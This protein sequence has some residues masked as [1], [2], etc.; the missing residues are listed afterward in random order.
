MDR[1]PV[2][3]P[4]RV[5]LARRWT[6]EIINTS[7]VPFARQEVQGFLAVHVDELLA[8][9]T[10]ADEPGP[11]A[12][13]VGSGLV[14]VHFTHTDALARTLRL[15]AAELPR[16]LPGAAPARIAAV[17]GALAAGFAGKL[18]C[19]TLEQQ[20]VIKQAVL[21]ARDA[22]EEA[23][24]ASEARSRAVFVSSAL[25]IA[26]ATL[27][28]TIEEVN[29]SMERI[30][31]CT[32]RRLVGDSM[33][34][35]A[36]Q[37]WIDD[38]RAAD[39]DL[40]VGRSE[41]FQRD[42]RFSGPDGAHI[43]TRLS[44][45]LVRDAHGEPD[46][47]V[48][49]YEDITERHM[50]QEQF[51]RQATHDPLTGLANRI[52]LKTTMDAALEPTHPGRRV[53][54]CYFDLDGFKAV[55]DSL[56]HP[57]GDDLLRAVAQRMQALTTGESMLTARMGGDEFVVL[58]ADSQGTARQLELVERIL[59]EITR[60]VRIGGHEL[61]A[62]ASVG[63]V[64]CEVAT[65]SPDELLRDADI[66]LY[67]AKADGRAQWMLFDPHRNADA[68][69]RFR[70]SA[71]MPAALEQNDMFVEYEPVVWLET[72][73]L[74]AA[75][76][77]LRWDHPELGEL[78]EEHF[79]ELA[80]ETGMITRLG[81]WLLE[82]V[83]EQAL[84]WARRF[85]RSAPI[86]RVNL[87]ARHFRDPELVGDLQRILRETGLPPGRLALGMPE[88]ALFD[89]SGDPLD[90]LDI[91][92]EMG[93][94]PTLFDFGRDLALIPRLRPL[95]LTAVQ[96]RGDYLDSFTEPAGPDPLDEHLVSSLAESARLLRVPVVAHGVRTDEQA[97]R[98]R[99]L[100]VRAVQGPY[101]GGR[102]SAGEI[103][104]ML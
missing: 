19:R 95:P 34:D 83:C 31:R 79:I 13:G 3:G 46:Y 8:A 44:A 61:T 65:T 92:A 69:R 9:M 64:E 74:V 52:L 50:L 39:G 23:L 18:R 91:I 51:R 35:L 80:E 30:F 88:S 29:P 36:D 26:I 37:D 86:A 54:L 98:L 67:R 82:R 42:L 48:L 97:K 10:A 6:Q 4:D 45:S 72:G 89:A 53:G 78:G 7:Y 75:D 93:V 22:A 96:I 70:L 103:E 63:V 32:G 2:S 14:E 17:L 68:R 59:A 41:R 100:G 66:T 99:Q 60:P 104:V 24:R 56:G 62:S 90:V 71:A 21:R 33:F 5:E 43:W 76:A 87:S 28:G 1:T 58:T 38:L 49:L 15:L 102:A 81:S 101:T 11:P 85:G 55:N 40:V 57:A 20:E 84:V 47:Q 77:Q 16:L 73:A 12:T 27:D 25:G 94:R